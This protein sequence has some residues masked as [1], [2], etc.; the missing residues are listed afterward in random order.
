MIEKKKKNYILSNPHMQGWYN[1]YKNNKQGKHPHKHTKDLF[2][3]LMQKKKALKMEKSVNIP[4]YNKSRQITEQT[5]L[6]RN[7]KDH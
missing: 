7:T 1:S 2:V 6:R 4:K 3:F 5:N